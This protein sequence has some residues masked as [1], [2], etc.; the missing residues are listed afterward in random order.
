MFLVRHVYCPL[1]LLSV[2]LIICYVYYPPG[3]SSVTFYSPSCLLSVTFMVH[4]GYCPLCLLSVTVI[5]RYIYWP[6]RLLSVMFNARHVYCPLHL[7]SVMF[8]VRYVYRP[9]WLMHITFIVRYVYSPLCLSFV[10][11]NARLIYCPICLLSVTFIRHVSLDKLILMEYVLLV[12]LSL[13]FYHL[14]FKF[15]SVAPNF[16][17]SSSMLASYIMG[18]SGEGLEICSK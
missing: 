10:M 14:F 13:W 5:V 4:H 1:H 17:L 6:S 11:F 12:K 2:M 3:S 15:I 18:R 9:I 7:W 16:L 8:I